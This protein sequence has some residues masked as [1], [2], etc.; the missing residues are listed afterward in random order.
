MKIF[1]VCLITCSYCFSELVDH[2]KKADNKS[3]L[4]KMKN[5]DFIYMIN[6][7]E[8]P[9]KF[10]QSLGEMEP[11]GIQP[12]RFSA[13]NGWELSIEAINDVGL[14]YK[15]GMTSLFATAFPFE[16]KGRHTNEFMKVYG[17][18]YF[19]HLMPRGSIGI[20]LSHISVLK[21]AWDSGYETIWVMEDDIVVNCNPH[22]L[23]D[24]IEKL[25]DLVGK[26][27]WDVLF[28]DKDTKGSDG[29]YIPAYGMAKRPDLDCSF[30]ERF[31]EKFTIKKQVSED[32]HK[33]TARFGA[34]SMIIRR[35]GI[36]KLLDYAMEHKIF[37]PYDFD[38]Y[39]APGISR[40][41]TNYDIVSPL[42]GALSDNATQGYKFSNFTLR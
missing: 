22:I 13:V 33:I 37:L 1:L 17:R 26:E 32:F 40:F 24:L 39:Q 34:Y 11:Y 20:C 30:Q 31:S 15:P 12:Y 10:A 41:S 28:T 36:K 35:S 4:H 7:D 27:N 19:C 8:R 6:L 25:D 2:L 9:E 3:D 38:N 18:A 5:I 14:I 42:I 23:S 16:A 29:N 21:D